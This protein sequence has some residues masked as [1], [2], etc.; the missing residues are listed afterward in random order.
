MQA[1]N[2]HVTTID[3]GYGLVLNI[4]DGEGTQTLEMNGIDEDEIIVVDK[5][6][7]NVYNGDGTSRNNLLNAYALPYFPTGEFTMTLTATTLYT[8]EPKVYVIPNWRRL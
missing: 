6:E 1:G 7:E 8:D 2:S 4:N 5:T 3:F